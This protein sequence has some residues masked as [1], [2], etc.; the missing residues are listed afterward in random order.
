MHPPSN[1]QCLL[2]VKLPLDPGVVLLD[3]AFTETDPNKGET[4]VPTACTAMQ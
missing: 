1:S 2:Q 4:G 3:I